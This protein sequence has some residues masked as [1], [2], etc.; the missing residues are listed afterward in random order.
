MENLIEEIKRIAR[1]AAEEKTREILLEKSKEA[2]SK[3]QEKNYQTGKSICQRYPISI[4]T[5]IRYRK[6]GRV[7]GYR[8]GGRVFYDLAEIEKSLRK[9]SR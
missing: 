6:A 9:T 1:E 2:E 8:I 3:D 7:K 5:L 4:Q